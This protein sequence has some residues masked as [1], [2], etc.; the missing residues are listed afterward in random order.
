MKML[1]ETTKEARRLAA[2]G[3]M[4]YSV[5]PQPDGTTL[6]SPGGW[7][8]AACRRYCR[9]EAVIPAEVRA[10]A[11]TTLPLQ[12]IQR[13][14]KAGCRLPTDDTRFWGNNGQDTDGQ[15]NVPVAQDA[16]VT[17]ETAPWTQHVALSAP[18]A[19]PDTTRPRIGMDRAQAEQLCARILRDGAGY[20]LQAVVHPGERSQYTILVTWQNDGTR[21]N[22]LH[23]ADWE[24]YWTAVQEVL[25]VS[26][27]H[28]LVL[29]SPATRS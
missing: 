9:P 4:Y 3:A 10:W 28:A 12:D 17:E 18:Q 8:T 27:R 20:A 13:L 22:I 26:T 19:T 29:A 5:F 24:T 14:V 7:F 23:E 16:C 11:E 21:V 6:Y 15:A 1:K 25:H 2:I